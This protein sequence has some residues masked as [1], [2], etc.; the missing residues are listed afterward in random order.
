MKLGGYSAV[1]DSAHCFSEQ[2]LWFK[3][4]KVKLDP[5]ASRLVVVAH[6]TRGNVLRDTSLI[7][8]IYTSY[9]L[10]VRRKS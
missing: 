2:V 7:Y 5:R 9:D 6:A 8:C 1:I 10:R 4:R 3:F